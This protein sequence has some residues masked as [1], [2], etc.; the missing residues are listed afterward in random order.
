MEEQVVLILHGW[1][2]N[3]PEHWQEHLYT[4]LVNANVPVHYPEMPYP[5]SPEPASW[6]AAVRKEM[7]KIAMHYPDVPLTVVAHSLGAITWL[8][9]VGAVAAAPMPLADRVLL[10]APPY[11]LPQAPPPDV[12]PGAPDFFPPP[13]YLSAIHATAREMLMVCG[14]NDDYATCD[15]TRG[16]G[17][18]LDI[19]VH[20]LPGAGHISPYY[21]Y[22]E[23]PWVMDWCLG[24]TTLPPQPK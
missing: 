21:G 16:Y 6:L 20:V 18:A 15:Q 22:G 8:H 1:G 11:L 13:L 24:K 14:D 23:W 12:P 10:V 5:A 9:V 4:A 3:K 7:G 2:G 17:A 19:P